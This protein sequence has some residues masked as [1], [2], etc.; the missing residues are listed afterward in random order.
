MATPLVVAR[1]ARTAR[2]LYPFALAAYERWQA[3]SDEDKERFKM[4][5]RVVAERGQQIGR[6]AYDRAQKRR[7][8]GRKKRR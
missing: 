2:R 6:D 4:R 7:G 8:G 1:A 3:L 5:A